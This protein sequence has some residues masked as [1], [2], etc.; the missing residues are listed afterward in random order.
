MNE[1][2][3]F[4]EILVVAGPLIKTMV[5]ALVTPKLKKMKERFTLDYK[6]YFVPTEDHFL[7][8]FHR[9]YKRLSIVNTLV[10]NNSQRLLTEI[11]QPLTISECKENGNRFKIDTYPEK[12]IDDYEKILITDTAGMGK[13]TVLKVIFLETIEKQKGIPILVELRRLSKEKSLIQEIQEQLSSIAKD[14]NPKLLLELLFEGGFLIILDGYDEIPFNEKELVTRDIQSFIIKAPKNKY[15]LSSRPESALSSFGDFQGFSI[16]PLKKKEAYDLLRKYDKQGQISGLLIRKLDEPNM[17]NIGEFLTNP[18]LVSLLF[19]AF[20]HKQTIPFKKYLFYRQVYDANFESHDL[21]KG[22]SYIHNK[23]SNLEIDDFHFVLRHLGFLCLKL[24]K[25][26][27]S[28]DEILE[29]IRESKNFCVNL[30]FSESDFLR[31][32]LITVPLFV[33]DGNYFKWS[34]KSLQEYFA[35]QFIYLDLKDKQIKILNQIY[36]SASL[37]KYINIL[38]L[39]ADIDPKTFRNVIIYELLKD[40][41][42][43]CNISYKSIDKSINQED[44]I[45]RK[46]LNFLNTPYIF[47]IN[48]GGENKKQFDEDKLDMMISK[49]R[50]I[51]GISGHLDSI[52]KKKELY[53]VTAVEPKEYLLHLLSKKKLSFVIDY[54]NGYTIKRG[55][56]L[57]HNISEEYK[58]ICITDKKDD[59]FNSSKNFKVLNQMIMFT[60]INKIR[61]NY[62]ESIL[63]L[64]QIEESKKSEKQDNYSLS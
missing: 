2:L 49:S 4:K 54:S 12:L 46:E 40:F 53:C 59:V 18:L 7:E 41:N 44:L 26:E 39:Y 48:R 31:D 20:Q 56:S 45:L 6:K 1:S 50:T 43:Y 64:H 19:T 11:Y 32:L 38:D 23:Y 34:H 15:L 61:M 36:N 24:Q 17:E 42:K 29:L 60:K 52:T 55:L 58:L 28:K 63:L 13:S 33:Q 8:Y 25:I 10:F 9:T 47:Y 16:E 37:E 62:D 21:T 27:F 14:F 35:A 57:D 22:D 3:P 51:R 5:E 30:Q